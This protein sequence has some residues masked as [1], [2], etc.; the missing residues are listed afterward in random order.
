MILDYD[1]P[2]QA[3]ND[4]VVVFDGI[5]PV[6][7]FVERRLERNMTCAADFLLRPG[8]TARHV[9][10]RPCHYLSSSEVA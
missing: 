7:E 4:I 2:W 5:E 1:F 10:A 8:T 6:P 3:E 9:R